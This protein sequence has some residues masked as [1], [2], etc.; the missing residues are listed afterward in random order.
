MLINNSNIPIRRDGKLT[1]R[2]ARFLILTG[3]LGAAGLDAQSISWQLSTAA[4]PAGAFPQPNAAGPGPYLKDLESYYGNDLLQT[5]KMLITSFSANG[6]GGSVTTYEYYSDAT[7]CPAAWVKTLYSWTFSP[8][9]TSVPANEKVTATYA[10]NQPKS[11]H[12]HDGVNGFPGEYASI[13]AFEGGTMSCAANCFYAEPRSAHAG[14]PNLTSRIL[15]ANATTGLPTS[16]STFT[17]GSDNPFQVVYPYNRVTA[18]SPQSK[19]ASWVTTQ[20]GFG[21]V[22]PNTFESY[23]H[24]LANLGIPATGW[25]LYSLVFHYQGGRTVVLWMTY[26]N[27]APNSVYMA[28]LDPITEKYVGWVLYH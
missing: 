28:Y 20:P 25:T 24:G 26:L 2:I 22:I 14:T 17:L 1:S 18:T 13:G 12:V 11:C 23:P 21:A 15:L 4:P 8:N 5:K 16:E 10:I 3:I 19:M 9:V 6:A 27:S 7:N